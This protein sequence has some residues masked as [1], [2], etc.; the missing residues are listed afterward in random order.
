MT[1]LERKNLR[2]SETVLLSVSHSCLRGPLLSYVS[3]D[4]SL[5]LQKS[6]FSHLHGRRLFAFLNEA[7]FCC[8]SELMWLGR[9]RA[10]PCSGH[11]DAGSCPGRERGQSRTLLLAAGSCQSGSGVFWN[12]SRYLRADSLWPVKPGCDRMLYFSLHLQELVAFKSMKVSA[13]LHILTCQYKG[14]RF[15]QDW[16][17]PARQAQHQAL[18][19]NR[20]TANTVSPPLS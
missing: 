16:L 20:N 8:G 12:L 18:Y 19:I 13:L 6:W 5:P 1:G 7:I 3:S 17:W 9:A 10:N 11:G 4:T 14:F 15:A 2:I